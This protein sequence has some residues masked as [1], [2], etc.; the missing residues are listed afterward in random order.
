MKLDQTETIMVSFAKERK[1]EVHDA[2]E[3]LVTSLA[4]KSGIAVA[5]GK[6]TPVQPSRP[7]DDAH[8]RDL[9]D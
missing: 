2:V 7:L 1:A 4:S 5:T 6:M 8:I 9:E 3:A